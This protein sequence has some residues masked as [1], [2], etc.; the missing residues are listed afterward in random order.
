[1][2]DNSKLIYWL[3]E[4]DNITDSFIKQFSPLSVEELNWKTNPETFSIA[5]NIEHLIKVNEI[6]YPVVDAIRKGNYKLPFTARF[7]F[8]TR[9]FGR[10]ILKAVEPERK[11]RIKTFSIWKPQIENIDA[12]IIKRFMIH[13]QELKDF[14]TNCQELIEK[15]TVIASPAN[16]NIVYKLEAAFDIIVAHE[17]RHFNQANE[18]LQLLKENQAVAK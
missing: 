18:I 6:Y 15:E 1:M 2:D 4:I 5:Q 11:K 12:S 17:K 9:F 14:V 10:F 7:S 3:S 8:V 16:R 13:Q